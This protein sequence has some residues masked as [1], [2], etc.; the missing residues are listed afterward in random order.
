MCVIL[1]PKTVYLCYQIY[2]YKLFPDTFIC[3]FVRQKIDKQKAA[4]FNNIPAAQ[5]KLVRSL[6]H[7]NKDQVFGC[8]MLPFL[9]HC[10]LKQPNTIRFKNDARNRILPPLGIA[11]KA[12][13]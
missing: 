11:C 13:V 4:L 8:R 7:T 9:Y 12:I 2:I 6:F 3:S 5:G 1:Q 10:G